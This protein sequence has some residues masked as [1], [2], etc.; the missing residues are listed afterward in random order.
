MKKTNLIVGVS[1]LLLISTVA[2]AV[3][4]KV[5]ITVNGK[6]LKTDV[7]TKVENGK[8]VT[9]LREIAEALGADVK[10]DNDT[11]TVHINAKEF[12]KD[13][14]TIIDIGES[15]KFDKTEIINAVTSVKNNFNFPKSTLT[16]IWYNEDYS[17]K[18]V[19][20]YLN[21]GKGIGSGIKPENIIVL[22]SDFDVDKSATPEETVLTPGQTYTNYHWVLIRDNKT[23]DWKVD[24][25]GY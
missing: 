11:K 7:L 1:S 19:G 22:L 17:N 25:W 9:P 15:I 23:R 24:S 21:N 5:N 10:W 20:F 6:V 8:T 13:Q 2:L 4:Q 3:N 14:D 12:D 16:K 18:Q